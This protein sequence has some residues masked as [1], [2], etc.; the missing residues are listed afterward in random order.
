MANFV[1]IFELA[2]LC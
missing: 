1:W 2:A